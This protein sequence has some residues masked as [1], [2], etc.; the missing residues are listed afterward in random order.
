MTWV[1]HERYCSRSELPNEDASQDHVHKRIQGNQ[2]YG[3]FWLYAN[4][5]DAIDARELGFGRDILDTHD[6]SVA[7]NRCDAADNPDRIASAFDE[8]CPRDSYTLEE[9]ESPKFA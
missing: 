3:S 4:S 1:A 6:G 9:E 8:R 7:A 2:G 5:A